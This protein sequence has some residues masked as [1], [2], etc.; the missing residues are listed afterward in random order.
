M[1][2]SSSIFTLERWHYNLRWKKSDETESVTILVYFC[3]FLVKFSSS[4]YSSVSQLNCHPRNLF[5]CLAFLFPVFLAPIQCF[6]TSSPAMLSHPSCP[7]CAAQW[8]LWT[9]FVSFKVPNSVL[10]SRM[11]VCPAHQQPSCIGLSVLL[12]LDASLNSAGLLHTDLLNYIHNCF[13]ELRQEPSLPSDVPLQIIFLLF[14]KTV[15]EQKDQK[16]H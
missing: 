3:Y 13:P 11:P 2:I 4:G 16:I 7:D 6:S 8:L 15:N 1:C 12:A 5:F 10:T 14:G 9:P